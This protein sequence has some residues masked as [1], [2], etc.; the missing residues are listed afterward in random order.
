MGV[1]KKKMQF[2]QLSQQFLKPVHIS[3]AI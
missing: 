2:Y 3:E 1:T